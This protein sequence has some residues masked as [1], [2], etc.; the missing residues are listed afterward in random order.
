MVT[1]AEGITSQIPKLSIGHDPE[2]V[3]TLCSIL[4]ENNIKVSI[5]K[6]DLLIN[7]SGF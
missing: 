4:G 1:E 7:I 3:A 5:F 2:P 6:K